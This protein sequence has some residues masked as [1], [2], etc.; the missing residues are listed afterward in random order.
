MELARGVT[1]RFT[2][3]PSNDIYPVWSP[4]GRRLMFGSDRDGG[5]FNLYQKL[6]NG[7]GD[8][9]RVVKSS[10]D[11]APLSWSPDG[12]SLLYRLHTQS[13]G[14]LPL[15]GDRK[16]RSLLES[17]AFGQNQG[18]VSPDGRWIVHTSNESGR[19][20]VYVRSFPAPAGKWQITQDGAYFPRWRGDGREVF[21]YGA[22]RRLMAVAITGETAVEAGTAV[23]LFEARMLN[24]PNTIAGFRA[25]YDVT[26][27]GQRFLLNVPVEDAAS[28][29]ITIVLNW[30]AALKK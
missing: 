13:L 24:G 15:V 25:Q 30:T 3:D 19:F 16:P 28:S 29:L 8:D 9:E 6:A 11:M 22:D 7:A 2:F 18:Q 27:D 21:Y 1:S 5:V 10:E 17:L 14:V 23:P 4:D 26:R 20:E 12:R